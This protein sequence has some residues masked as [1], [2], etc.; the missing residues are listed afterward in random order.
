MT[1]NFFTNFQKFLILKGSKFYSGNGPNSKNI[2]VTQ[3]I[4]FKI[5]STTGS[6]TIASFKV[7]STVDHRKI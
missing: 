7:I 3:K 2:K 6:K 1:K 5:Y 4:D